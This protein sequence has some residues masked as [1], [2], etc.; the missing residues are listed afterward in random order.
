MHPILKTGRQVRGQHW[1]P[2]GRG[3]EGTRE[4]L[5]ATPVFSKP[6]P[7][8]TGTEPTSVGSLGE[9]GGAREIVS[10]EGPLFDPRMAED[11]KARRNEIQVAFVDEP[12]T[13]VER[14]DSL[15]A[16]TTR[17]LADSFAAERQRLESEWGRGSEAS[18]DCLRFAFQHYRSFFNRMLAI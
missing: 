17:H 18:T 5:E 1:C 8:A 9:T 7:I 6:E 13:A 12:R 11:F 10:G 3:E 15:V 14:A 4:P 2:T 16:E